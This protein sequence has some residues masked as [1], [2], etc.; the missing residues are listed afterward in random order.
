MPALKTEKR[1]LF[2]Q[3]LS[4]GLSIVQ[5]ARNA[6]FTGKSAQTTGSH[7]AK[8]KDVIAR[9]AE[10]K[11]K[12]TEYQSKAAKIAL[13]QA[14]ETMPTREAAFVLQAVRERQ[15]RLTV[16][17]DI[18]DRL[19]MVID[20]RAAAGRVLG[21]GAAPGAG[22]GLLVR[23]LKSLRDGKKIKIH[24]FWEIDGVTIQKLY[25]GL[26]QAAIEAGEWQEEARAQPQQGPDLSHLTPAQL[27]E[28]QRILRE[29]MEGIERVRAGDLAPVMLEAAAGS[30]R[31]AT[32]ETADSADS[33][34]IPAVPAVDLTGQDR[35]I[36]R[37]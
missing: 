16:I 22:T 27:F 4:K 8:S 29:A 21:D 26:K 5:A 32:E 33:A 35:L 36:D 18:V 6:G 1:E 31:D 19:R 2:A 28:E 14:L 13:E 34:G 25:D 3:E 37:D 10:L 15:Y 30:V 12:V 17:Q 7:L 9:V 24:E 20:E 23:T 11:S